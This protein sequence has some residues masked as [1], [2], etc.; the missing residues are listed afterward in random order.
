MTRLLTN[1]KFWL[2]AI[3]VTWIAVVTVLIAEA[4]V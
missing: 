1:V 3:I 4:P 2:L